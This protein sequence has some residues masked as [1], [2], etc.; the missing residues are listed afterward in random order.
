MRTG[1]MRA[2]ELSLSHTL[3]L[4]FGPSLWSLAGPGMRAHTGRAAPGPGLKNSGIRGIFVS[5]VMGPAI[6]NRQ[7]PLWCKGRRGRGCRG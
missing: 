4:V 1:G 3:A 7:E 5:L 6:I 2:R